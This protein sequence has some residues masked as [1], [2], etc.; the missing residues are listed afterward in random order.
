[1]NVQRAG[2]RVAEARE[3]VASIRAQ[4]LTGFLNQRE[5]VPGLYAGF[6]QCGREPPGS[7]EAEQNLVQIRPNHGLTL[8]RIV[9]RRYDHSHL[10]REGPEV[11]PQTV[12]AGDR[13]ILER[14]VPAATRITL[15]TR[16]RRKLARVPREDEGDGHGRGQSFRHAVIDFG[17]ETRGHTLSARP[18]RPSV[19]M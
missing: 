14:L 11:V 5:R 6:G 19:R 12:A 2:E 18:D 16:E 13:E 10:R 4:V 8:V 3:Q 9:V 17:K 1:M 7:T 15:E